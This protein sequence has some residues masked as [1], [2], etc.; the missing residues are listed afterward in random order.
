[1]TFVPELSL[2]FLCA[3]G[4]A[5]FAATSDALCKQ[6]LR[7]HPSVLVAWVR[8]LYTVPF[9]F[10]TFFFIEGPAPDRFF[11]FLLL[12]LVPME[13]LALILYMKALQVSPLSLTVPFLALTPAFTLGTSFLLLGELPDASGF[14]G[15]LLIVAGAYLLN[16]HLSSKG[17][18]EPLR[19]VQREK[20]SMMMIAVAFLYSITSNVGKIAIQ[21]SNPSFMSAIY[22][23]FLSVAFLPVCLRL[24]GRISA[25]RS[26]G[27]LFVLI[28][29]SQAM[30]VIF[31]FQAISM[32]L[33]PYMIS[34]KRL[35][36]LMSVLVGFLFFHEEHLRERLFGSFVMLCGVYLIL[37]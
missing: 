3:L 28:G 1:V 16:V 34:V 29:A 7:K 26:G 25:L 18:L 22:F 30:M 9:L 32:I 17:L 36:L 4:A 23:P 24:G 12:I 2:G 11:W 10:I 13:V 21:H 27:L 19:A 15:V 6:A 8:L 37:I 33:V 5:V 31:H 20:G 35:S 14:C